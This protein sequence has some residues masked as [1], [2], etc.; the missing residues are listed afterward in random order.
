MTELFPQQF[1]LQQQDQSS[2]SPEQMYPQQILN[3]KQL[4]EKEG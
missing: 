1:R 3:L 2:I 4:L